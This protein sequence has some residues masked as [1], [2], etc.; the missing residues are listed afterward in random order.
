L[1]SEKNR[2]RENTV[3]AKRKPD[4]CNQGIEIESKEAQNPWRDEE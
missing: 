2:F 3:V 4:R 1:G